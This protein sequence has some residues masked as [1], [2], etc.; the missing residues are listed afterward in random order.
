MVSLPEIIRHEAEVDTRHSAPIE[1]AMPNET[2]GY[3]WKRETGEIE[4]YKHDHTGG[5]LHID[6]AANFYD[7]EAQPITRENALENASH[8][9]VQSVDNNSHSQSP[10]N[11]NNDQGSAFSHR[12][13]MLCISIQLSATSRR[14]NLVPML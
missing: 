4:S 13:R 7:S 3:E 2:A 6:P 11:E 14:R 10:R 5:W 12:H 1:A 8:S 9:Q